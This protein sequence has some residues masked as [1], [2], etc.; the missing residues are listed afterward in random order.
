MP[1]VLRDLLS[2]HINIPISTDLLSDDSINEAWTNAKEYWYKYKLRPRGAVTITVTSSGLYTFE[3]PIPVD[4][5]EVRKLPSALYV[6]SR[7][8]SYTA[9]TIVIEQGDYVIVYYTD[10]NLSNI[11]PENLPVYLKRL[12]YAYCKQQIGQF[13]K[14]AEFPDKPFQI[15][16]DRIYTEGNSE[17]ERYEEYIM[18]HRD[19]KTS[20]LSDLR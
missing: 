4:I 10:F 17:Q 3:E 15:D 12:F 11:N 5:A 2:S 1:V 9:P 8:F 18:K 20:D 13:L 19:E 6:S 16:G 7:D 14:F